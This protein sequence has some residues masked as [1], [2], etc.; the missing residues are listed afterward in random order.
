MTP[1]SKPDDGVFD[2][3]I[4]D[5][6][7]PIRVLGLIPHFL[8]GTQENQKEISIVRAKAVKVKALEG[9]LAG[10][11]DGET[12]CERGKAVDVKLLPKQLQIV[13]KAD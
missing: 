11:V 10:H 12:L 1:N 8:K 3:C 4:A 6:P 9:V 5:A 13:C 7:G 2:I